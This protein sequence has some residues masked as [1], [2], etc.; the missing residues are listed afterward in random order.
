MSGAGT[1]NEI[2]QCQRVCFHARC[3]FEPAESTQVALFLIGSPDV[4][5]ELSARKR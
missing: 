1:L 4:S 3:D 5:S 2:S